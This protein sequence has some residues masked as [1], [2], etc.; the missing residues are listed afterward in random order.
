MTAGGGKPCPGTR[1]PG[2]AAAPARRAPDAMPAYRFCRPDDV[3]RLVRAVNRCYDVHFPGAPPLTVAG[4]RA[5]MKELDV[6]P[7]SSMVALAGDEPIAVLIGT[8]REREVLVVRLGVRPDHLRRGH[9]A[10]LVT[11][12][13]QKLAV[14]G[15]PRLVAEVPLDLPAAAAFFAALGYRREADF[16]DWTRLPGGAEPVPA[17]LTVPV[18]VDDVA[19]AG[20]LEPAA[21]VAWER[22]RESLVGSKDAFDGLAIATPERLEAYVLA[23][24]REDAVDVVAASCRDPA[25]AEVYLGLLLRAVVGGAGAV[26]VRLP[27]LADGELPP[28]VLER[29]GFAPGRRY[30]RFAVVARAA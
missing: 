20:L 25:Q 30:A 17:E 11:S 28:A 2:T 3:P 23:R 29:L 12:L 9:G 27:R 4:L 22:A 5:E 10:H 7:S 15:P 24:P 21:G 13:G 18:T 26:T 1:V 16:T 6:W 19:D 14:L 8:R